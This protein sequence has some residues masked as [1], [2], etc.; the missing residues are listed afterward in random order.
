MRTS[1]VG[2]ARDTTFRGQN[3][4]SVTTVEGAFQESSGFLQQQNERQAKKQKNTK[5]KRQAPTRTAKKQNVLPNIHT[6]P[7]AAILQSHMHHVSAKLQ[8]LSNQ[9]RALH[10]YQTS[11]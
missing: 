8:S 3:K 1:S 5:Q 11:I 9:R 4:K 2:P 6:D 10:G 7:N